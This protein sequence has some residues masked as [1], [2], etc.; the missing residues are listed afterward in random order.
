MNI[1][2][3]LSFGYWAYF[4]PEMHLLSNRKCHHLLAFQSLG[5]KEAIL[6]NSVS[7]GFLL[8]Q[9]NCSIAIISYYAH[10]LIIL[11]K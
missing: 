7:F 6:V 3:M 8:A 2:N 10:T 4:S 11:R 5:G 1:A 9:A